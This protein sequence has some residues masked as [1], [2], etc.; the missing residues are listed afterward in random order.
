[1]CGM[2]LQ[3]LYAVYFALR[4]KRAIQEF[5]LHTPQPPT[6]MTPGSL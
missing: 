2:P 5:S 3:A 1:M 6:L 4:Q